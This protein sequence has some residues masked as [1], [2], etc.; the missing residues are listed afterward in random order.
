MIYE[1]RILLSSAA[2][3]VWVP[4]P[5]TP[6]WD[7]HKRW[8]AIRIEPAIRVGRC[9]FHRQAFGAK[10]APIAPGQVP[11]GLYRL[12]ETPEQ[13]LLILAPRN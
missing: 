2:A 12:S 9:T 7:L 11:C 3:I 4:K 1:A 13:F 5:V 6:L 8:H 10:Q